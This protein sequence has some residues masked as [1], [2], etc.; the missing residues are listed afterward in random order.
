MNKISVAYF[1][2]ER[3]NQS[4]IGDIPTEFCISIPCL[5]NKSGVVC[6][7]WYYVYFSLKAKIYLS[8]LWISY[9]K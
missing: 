4:G 2:F 5:W 8:V 3:K 6:V 7:S 1:A 9:K